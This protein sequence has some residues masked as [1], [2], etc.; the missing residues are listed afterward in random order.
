MFKDFFEERKEAEKS[1]CCGNFWRLMAAA[2][3]GA[4]ALAAV[5]AVLTKLQNV[6]YKEKLIELSK[7]LPNTPEQEAELEEILKRE[8]AE[9]HSPA[10]RKTTEERPAENE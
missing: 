8:Q 1:K 5:C 2:A 6:K 10:D 4:A 3:A 9:A 7:S